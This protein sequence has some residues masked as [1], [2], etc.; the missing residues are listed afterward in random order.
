M[1]NEMSIKIKTP[2]GFSDIG[3]RNVQQDA[4]YPL[5]QDFCPEDR[6]FIICDGMGGHLKGEVASNTIV[7]Y[8]CQHINAYKENLSIEVF[9]KILEKAWMELDT[10]YDSHLGE[11]QMGTTLAFLA[12]SQK[13]YLAAHIGDSRIY[14]IRPSKITNI[15]YRTRDHS[16]ISTLLENGDITPIE[17][18]SY[19][20]KNILNRAMIPQT[21]Y[22]PEIYEGT[23][24]KE[25]DFFMLCSDGVTEFLS[26]DMIRFIFAP[27]RSAEDIYTLIHLHCQQL[28]S[29]NNTCVIIPVDSISNNTLTTQL[30][31]TG[32]KQRPIW[33]D[34]D[35]LRESII[36]FT[37]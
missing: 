15:L 5:V 27:Y 8:I 16:H 10:L 22:E 36:H 11:F 26:D 6:I 3:S 34:D 19:E 13:G 37:K 12:F 18:L 20:N 21:R 24:I 31:D 2:L 1:N 9:E 29:D 4:I 14:H 23:D 35:L 17:A 7:N 33:H 32:S 30:P 28:S 25:G